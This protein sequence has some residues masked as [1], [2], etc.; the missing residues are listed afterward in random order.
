MKTIDEVICHL[1]KART[2]LV[3]GSEACEIADSMPYPYKNTLMFI[4]TALMWSPVAEFM[5]VNE[6][7]GPNLGK[8]GE[9]R[10]NG[11]TRGRRSHDRHPTNTLAWAKTGVF[12]VCWW[13]YRDRI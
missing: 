8:F 13:E 10:E 2:E 7:F 11:R 3:E 12:A 6:Q 5:V 4:E 1:R 9:I